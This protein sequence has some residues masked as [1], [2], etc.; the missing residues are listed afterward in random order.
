MTSELARRIAFTLGALLIY[1]LGTYIPLPGVN[2]INPGIGSAYAP[3]SIF[4]IGILPY[5]YAAILIQMASMV[6]SRLSVARD[7][8]AGRRK[9]A[10]YTI[11]LAVLLAAFQSWGIATGLEGIANAVRDPGLLFRLSTAITLT[12]GTIF[13]VWLSQQITARGIGNGLAFILFTGIAA[14]L[15]RQVAMVAELTRRGSLSG[16]QVTLLVVLWVALVGLV[17]FVELAHRRVPVDFAARRLGDRTL[18]A[19][20]GYLPFKLNNAGLLPAVIVPWL[21]SL[22]YILAGLVMIPFSPSLAAA[23]AKVQLGHVEYTV[24]LSITVFIFVFIYTSFVADPERSADSLM[25]QGGVIPGV[26]PGEPT[27]EYLDGIVSRTTLVGAL[28]LAAI[29]LIPELLVSYT[30]APFYLGGASLLIVVCAVLDIEK[31]VRGLTLTK[32]GGERA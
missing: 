21:F 18:P 20:L 27:A 13:L 6:S 29:L 16:N 3:V 1:R 9:I 31:Q 30:Q 2:Y 32:P 17:V 19:R 28:Y 26:M 5:L 24:L 10:R 12:G 8:E 23:Y 11:V 25:K 15:P 22:L 7:S 14:R 4:S